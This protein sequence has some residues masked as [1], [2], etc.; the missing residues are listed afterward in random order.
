MSVE[1][2]LRQAWGFYRKFFLR[3]VLTAAVAFMVLELFPTLLQSSTHSGHWTSAIIWGIASFLLWI[4]GAFWLQGALV[5]A[6][7]DLRDGRIDLSIEDLYMRTRPLLPGLIAAGLAAVLGVVCGL[8]LLVIP[9]LVL[10]TRWI[11]FVPV[12]VLEKKPAGKALNRSWNLVKGSSWSM[13]AL[14]L[15]TIFVLAVGSALIRVALF[16]LSSVPGF[17]TTW[18]A[19]T[20]VSSL[21][22]PFAALA[23]T[24]AYFEL[25]SERARPRATMMP[26]IQV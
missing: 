14:M 7:N 12:I 3:L 5:E 10:M 16:P 23:W 17:F 20:I 8:V 2:I 26:P 18:V 9:G 15:V 19:S 24:F 21:T 6:I 22:A 25:V 11:L 4:V 13:F 1:R